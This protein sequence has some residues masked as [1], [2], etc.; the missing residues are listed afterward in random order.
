MNMDNEQAKSRKL[1][2]QQEINKTVCF[3]S[4]SYFK[5]SEQLQIEK[6]S[7]LECIM[8][9]DFECWKLNFG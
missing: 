2:K 5:R 4:L 8:E 1:T 7:N 3:L 9:P 6:E